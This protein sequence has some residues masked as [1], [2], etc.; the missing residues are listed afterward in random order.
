MA[1]QFIPA[2]QLVPKFQGIGRCSNYAVLQTV[3]LQQFWKTV[4][5]LPDTKDTIK[6]LIP[7]LQ[8]LKDDYH[9]IK[10]YIPLVR[11]YTTGNVTV[12]EMLISNAF[13]TDEIRATDDF[14]EYETVIIGVDVKMNQLQPVV[15]TQGMHMITPRAYRTPTLT[16]ASPQEKKRKQRVG[17]TSSPMKS[18]KVTIKQNQTLLQ[19]HLLVMKEYEM[20]LLR[21]ILKRWLKDRAPESHK[22]KPKVV[23]MMMLL[24]RKMIRGLTMK[25]KVYDV[26][27]NTDDAA[28]ENG[29]NGSLLIIHW[30]KLCNGATTSKSKSK[31]GF[32]SNKTKILPGSIAGMCRRR[33]TKDREI[34]PTNVPELISKELATHAPKM[35]EELFQKHMQNTTLNMYPTT[36]SS[37]TEISTADLQHQL[38]LKMKSKP[39]DQAVDP[40]L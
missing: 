30:S 19:F 21:W 24:T 23:V 35:I 2:A 39:Q 32:T 5:K 11:V 6:N 36:S 17:E 22:A 16:A 27:R 31:R 12:R 3:Y 9:S 8:R 7:F 29:Q 28:K 10:D 26:L 33:V 4:S 20:K 25:R 40:E 37:T 1:Q 15:S 13:L 38:Y 18:L 14:K 34:T